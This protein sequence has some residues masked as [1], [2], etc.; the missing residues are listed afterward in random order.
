MFLNYLKRF[1][2]KKTLKKQLNNVKEDFL[3]APVTR[4]GLLVDE[5]N[6]METNTLKQE[7]INNG[8]LEN[9]I[10]II[11]YRDNV[12]GKEIYL[13][14]TFGVKDLNLKC[15]FIPNEINEFISEEFDLLVNYYN[16]EKPFLL[17]LTNNSKAKFKI[18]FSTV[19]ARLN[20]L[21]INIALENYK[22]F[23]KEVFRYL[24][25]LNKI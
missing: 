2:L 7:I 22:G 6:F 1:L 21:L 20:H 5:S 3:I 25:I 17:L 24:K 13:Q 12:K 19:D 9:N 4:V 23:T 14:P 18:G 10:K 8:I 16:E 11:V 15:K